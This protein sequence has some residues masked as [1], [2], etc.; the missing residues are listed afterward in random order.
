MNASREE[1]IRKHGLQL[2][3]IF[4]NA[5]EADPVK[6]CKKLR[7]LE[8]KAN[9]AAVDLCNV[10]NY[11]DKADA[12]FE[13]VGAKVND[14]LGNKREYQPKTGARCSCRPGVQR[15]NCSA[16]EGTG[17][18]IDFKRIRNAPPLVPVIINRDPRGYALK[19]DDAWFVNA[20][21]GANLH[22]DMGGYGII[23]PEIE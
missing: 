13:D 9:Q 17:H 16:C 6:L 12:I 10:P 18:C 15:D 7:R 8:L 5:K 22:T 21:R 11:Q 23:A 20:V 4:P 3:A 14:L 1:R 19:I 2:L